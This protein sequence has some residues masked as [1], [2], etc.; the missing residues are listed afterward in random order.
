MSY[1]ETLAGMVGKSGLTLREIAGR[2][3]EF[4]VSIDPSY[5]S[6]LQSGSQSPASDEI[7]TAL[8]KA[9]GENPEDLL[10]EAYMD[11]AP[12]LMQQ[13]I[14]QLLSFFR[15]VAGI[16]AASLPE[17]MATITH[18]TFIDLP[19]R[20]LMRRILREEE[21]RD[22]IKAVFVSA[23][24]EPAD[25]SFRDNNLNLSMLQLLGITMPD[26]AMAPLIPAGARLSLDYTEAGL[27]DIVLATLPDGTNTV[28]RYVPAGDK[29]ILLAT[30]PTLAPLTYD[31]AAVKIIGR[32]KSF[33][34]SI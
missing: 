29:V 16:L 9:C 19:D 11:K 23:L 27:G 24:S 13:F 6:K 20:V 25:F 21:L 3:Q 33:A 14:G 5:I 8:A 31:A 15:E 26:T 32:V 7:N 2:C 4:G 22:A 17:N 12:A 10:F 34:H 28:R 1:S 30:D 18:T